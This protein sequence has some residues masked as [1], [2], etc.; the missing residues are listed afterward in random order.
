[1]NN[2]LP[3]PIMNQNAYLT[4]E[5]SLHRMQPTSEQRAFDD[6]EGLK[7]KYTALKMQSEISPRLQAFYEPQIATVES[8]IMTRVVELEAYDKQ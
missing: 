8:M 1:M 3:E 6:L 4:T 2:K 7:A 5:Q